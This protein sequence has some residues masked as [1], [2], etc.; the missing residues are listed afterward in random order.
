MHPRVDSAATPAFTT[1]DRALGSA[2]VVVSGSPSTGEDK[3]QG[4]GRKARKVEVK[5][6]DHVQHWTCF[7]REGRGGEV[8]GKGAHIYILFCFQKEGKEATKGGGEMRVRK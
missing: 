3:P 6:S 8:V 2:A 5:T 7:G 1:S 4:W